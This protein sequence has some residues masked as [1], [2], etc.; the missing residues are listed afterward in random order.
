[1]VT[2]K[3]FLF[4]L[5]AAFALTLSGCKK[6][7]GGDQ[8]ADAPIR[9]GEV[10]S[11]TGLEATFGTSTHQG[12][13]LAVKKINAEGGINGRKVDL[14]TLDNQGKADE[15][16]TATTRLVTQDGVVAI[17]GEVASSRSLAMA[18]IAQS[19]KVPMISPSSTNPAVTQQGDHIFRVCFIDPF[20]GE[21]MAK[22]ALNGLKIERVAIMTDVKNDYSI[23]LVEFFRKNFVEGGGKIVMEQ[24]YSNGDT[25]FKAQLTSIASHNPEAI[26]VPGYYGDVALIARQARE[27]GIKAPLLGGDGWDSPK[28]LEI[29]GASLNGS[30]FSSHYSP[31]DTSPRIQGFIKEFKDAYGLVPDGLAATGHDAMLVLA[32]A[33]KRAKSLTPS[34]IRDAIAATKDFPGVTGNI[35]I[36]EN[37]NAR[38]PAVVLKI[39][40]QKLVY[41]TTINP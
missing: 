18:P 35:T 1:M 30:Y 41:E 32:D 3:K 37:R 6:A 13:E 7:P 21:V 26:F 40:D 27:V 5:L 2:A 4:A 34:D 22:F 24:S 20:Q 36:D 15:A 19:Y 25:D 12:I 8:S 23:G 28:L 39:E 14:I 16:A 31:Q 10:G 29:G 38:K 11:L 17:L 33:M 9:V